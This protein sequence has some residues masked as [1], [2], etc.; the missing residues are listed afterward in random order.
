[1]FGIAF[2]TF[3]ARFG[4]QRRL[5]NFAHGHL[6]LGEGCLAF[7]KNIVKI[8][9]NPWYLTKKPYICIGQAAQWEIGGRLS[10]RSFALPLALVA[11]A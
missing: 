9:R 11:R 10:F 3:V 1:M 8:A 2:L 5:G 7:T 6:M 4:W